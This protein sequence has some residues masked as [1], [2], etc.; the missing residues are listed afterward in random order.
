MR[1]SCKWILTLG[2]LAVTPGLQA[3][4]PFS[5]GLSKRDGDSS[6]AAAQNSKSNNQRIA[7]Q[8]ALR[9]GRPNS[10]VTKSISNSRME[11]PFSAERSPTS[12]KGFKPA[13]LW[14]RCRKFAAWITS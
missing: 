6:S 1:R 9:C 12:S 3:A 8:I 2:I 13:R 11:Q 4:G 7:E 14:A 10:M 5:F